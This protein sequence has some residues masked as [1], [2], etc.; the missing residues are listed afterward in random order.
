MPSSVADL[1]FRSTAL[2]SREEFA[3]LSRAMKPLLDRRF[4]DELRLATADGS[5]AYE[6]VCAVC[7][8]PA[9]FLSST[10][11]GDGVGD[12]RRLPNWRE[13]LK[14]DRCG[15]ST[16]ERA[17]MHA[18]KTFA[19]HGGDR[20]ILVLGTKT[21]LNP[22]LERNASVV[23]DLVPPASG[24]IELPYSAVDTAVASDWLDKAPK[25]DAL[26]REVVRVLKPGGRLLFTAPFHYA[27]ELSTPAEGGRE[28]AS[29]GWDLLTR[30]RAAGFAQAH[31]HLYWSEE[32][33]YL[34]PFNFVF[35]ARKS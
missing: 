23:H 6:G 24:R 13:Q 17:L 19:E 20:E 8:R 35:V 30:L 29:F 33:A 1:P 25:L 34:G 27:D 10:E 22:W 2:A 21:D 7:G 32:L 3:V 5:F 12:G 15:L 14:C 31:A 4:E 16:R 11:G 9:E 26:L 28:A 18:L